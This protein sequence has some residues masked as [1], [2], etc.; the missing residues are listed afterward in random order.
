MMFWC[1]LRVGANDDYNFKN[2]ETEFVQ[3]P[4]TLQK[5]T[6]ER[7]LILKNITTRHLES[8]PVEAFFFF[9]V[10]G[11][12]CGSSRRLGARGTRERCPATAISVAPL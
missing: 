12:D 3:Y 10:Q 9:F 7:F 8:G 11:F 1:V 5:K 6:V 4:S 2:T